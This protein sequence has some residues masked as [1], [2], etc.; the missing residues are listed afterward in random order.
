[1]ADA[2]FKILPYEATNPRDVSF[3]VNNIMNGKINS[4]GTL[5]CT[6]SAATTAVTDQ[7]AGKTSVILLMPLTANA[8]TEQGNGTIFVSTRADK[9]F[10]V[11]HANN[12]QSDR[13]F[14][15]VIIG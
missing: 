14:A 5:T 11:T 13:N 9:S 6:A 1:M 12:S 15:Y 2:N 7:R 3:V 4:T 10:T 8:A